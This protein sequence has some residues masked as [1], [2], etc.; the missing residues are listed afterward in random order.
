GPGSVDPATGIF[1][2]RA[3]VSSSGTT[4]NVSI[5]VTDNGSPN[6]SS[7]NSFKVIVVP[8]A[9]PTASVPTFSNG[10]FSMT[11]A[12]DFAA[13]YIVQTSTNLTDWQNLFTNHSPTVPFTFTDTNAVAPTQFY[14]ILL[15]P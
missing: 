4:N 11:V 7:T 6:L 3:P 14:R 8:V 9:Q 12:G 13:D 2:W 15:G 5:A 10:Q 1:T